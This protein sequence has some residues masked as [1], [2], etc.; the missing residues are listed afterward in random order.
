M[1]LSPECV[2]MEEKDII[3]RFFAFHSIADFF[4]VPVTSP[5][6]FFCEG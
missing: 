1:S 2:I 5:N 6:V 3:W 4:F